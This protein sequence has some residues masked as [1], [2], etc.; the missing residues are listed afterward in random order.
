M[1]RYRVVGSALVGVQENY[2]GGD[3]GVL[4][5]VNPDLAGQVLVAVQ[6]RPTA[7]GRPYYA[8]MEP[9]ARQ[10]SHFVLEGDHLVPLSQ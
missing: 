6:G 5:Y 3:S 7:E 9:G 2:T 4:L 8:L 10:M 1:R